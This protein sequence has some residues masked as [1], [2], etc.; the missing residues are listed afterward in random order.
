MIDEI[1]N[2]EIIFFVIYHKKKKEWHRGG[3][4]FF[5]GTN[6][7]GDAEFYKSKALAMYMIK[8]LTENG[9]NGQDTIDDYCLIKYKA[10]AEDVLEM[11]D[12]IDKEERKE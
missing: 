9:Y 5:N 4:P 12:V 6:Y 1:K 3:E 2:K 7:V 10:S 11:S 8:E